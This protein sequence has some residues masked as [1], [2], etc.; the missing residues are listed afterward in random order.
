M[1]TPVE[2]IKE[3]LNIVDVVQEYVPLKKAGAN[4]KARCPFHNEKTPSFTVSEAKQF[5]HCFG[6]GKGGDIF[7]FIQEI[8]NVEFA[9]ALRMLAQKANVELRPTNPREHNE[10]TR[11]LDCLKLASDFYHAAL[12]ESNEGEKAR[13]YL[14][15]RGLEPE[16]IETF[17]LGYSADAWDT[18]LQFLK[19]KG[20]KEKEIERAGL[21]VP[22]AKT[23]GYYDRFRGRLLFPIHNSHGNVIGFGGRTLDPNQK[24]A[25]YINSPQTAVYNKSTVLYG[26]HLAKQ[27]IKKMDAAV[28]VEGYMDVT[29]AHQAKFRN[30]VAASG[31]ALTHDQ[32]RV[33]KR[34]SSNVIL[35]FDADAAGLSAAWRGMQVAIQEGMNIKVLVLPSG[36]DP[37]DLIRKNPQEFRQRAIEAKPFMDH[38]FDS[39]LTPLDLTNVHHKKKA[40]AELLP[41]IALFPDTIEQSH[42]LKLLAEKVDVD[43]PVLQEKIIT[44]QK[45]AKAQQR[46]TV[47]TGSYVQSREISGETPHNQ[48]TTSPDEPKSRVEKM[49]ELL[50]AIIAAYPENFSTLQHKMKEGLIE[51]ED[52]QKLYKYLESFYNQ[53]GNLEPEKLVF[54]D[55]NSPG[56]WNR[57]QIIGEEQYAE[58]TPE[59]AQKELLTLIESLER[60]RIKR[61]LKQVEHKLATAEKNNDTSAIQMLSDDFRELTELLRKLG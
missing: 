35:A 18:L 22:S 14:K 8:E 33:L 47:T 19:K 3:R 13:V 55:A 9:E 1:S 41:M 54:E 44:L 40:A 38:A 25:K 17:R 2:E 48:S 20:Y 59:F 31:T 34:F 37:D 61:R 29:T 46:I 23:G 45:K 60:E 11:L 7:T 53:S 51:G 4:H 5:F 49:S 30:V 52:I 16:T 43:F 56:V 10:K 28:I 50:L 12:K 32:I 42:Y 57:I 27:Y 6:C 21:I 15:E 39:I 26:L 36:Q 58:Q 24:E